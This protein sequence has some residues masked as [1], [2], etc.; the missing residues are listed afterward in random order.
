MNMHINKDTFYNSLFEHGPDIIL[1]LDKE[2][3][4]ANAN[5]N[6]Y[7]VIGY[8]VEEV[9]HTPL[10][11]Y[12]AENEQKN[13]QNI[14]LEVLKGET[15]S[16]DSVII[17]KNGISLSTH[18]I[19]IPATVE[20]K[21][22]GVYGII[23]DK[24]ETIKIENSLRASE[25][26][27]KAIVEEA[28][29]G[30]YILKDKHLIYGNPYYHQ[31]LG[32]KYPDVNFDIFNYIHPEDIN[33]LQSIFDSLPV[34][35]NGKTHYCRVIRKNG[36]ERKIEAHSKLIYLNREPIILGTII[37]VTE[38]EK[39]LEKINF[40]AYFDQLTKLPNRKSFEEVLDKELVIAKTLNQKLAIMYLDLDRFKY[41][42]DTLGYR[43]GEELLIAI[44]KRL[45]IILGD[46]RQLFRISGE[47]YAIIIQDYRTLNMVFD[48]AKQIISSMGEEFVVEH[49][50]LFLNTSIGISL[51]PNDGEDI[52]SLMKNAAAALLNS[53]QEGKNT[54]K[55]YSSTMDIRTFRAFKLG[56]DIR[57]A[58]ENDQLEYYFQPKV[59]T[60]NNQ[61]IG[62][63]ALIRW[64][65]PEWGILSPNEF[66]PVIEENGLIAEIDQKMNLIL[67]K[68]ITTWQ[69][70][71]LP[72][73]TVSMN[74]S[75]K[76]FLDKNLVSNFQ[77]ILAETKLAPEFIEIEIIE[78]SMLE[79][80]KIV[81]STLNDLIKTGIAISLDD[82][83][84]GYSSLSYLTKFKKYIKT[85]KI[86]R[87]FITE[88]SSD[89]ENE[90]NFITQTMIKLAE[91]MKMSVVAEGVETLEQY[92]LLKQMGCKIVQGYLFSKPIPANEFEELL[93]HGII[94]ITNDI[95]LEN[96]TIEDKR[97][98][99][100]VSLHFPLSGTMTLTRINGRTVDVGKTVVIIENIGLGGLRFITDLKLTVNPNILFEF[101]V[102]LFGETIKLLG[103]IVWM[104]ENKPDI[105]Q[106]GLEYAID[107]SRRSEITPIL[108]KLAL[109]LRNAPLVPDCSFV[110]EDRYTFIK[111]LRS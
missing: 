72:Q 31:L 21:V 90:S 59:S 96:P 102:Y 23:I 17:H 108:N 76:R 98:F 38:R 104:N 26:K 29:V 100:R 101:E 1:F 78:T 106:Y 82:F 16:M 42:N 56:S 22:T 55:T 105:Y 92:H 64:N 83:G 52:I 77:E 30:V 40:L 7:K 43:V 32:T 71:G 94:D 89:E 54:F 66:L 8:S 19:L 97:K 103:T 80:E 69:E 33:E 109:K 15:I 49:Y 45:Q 95:N 81:L 44:S 4:I 62:A 41:T 46:E 84:T 99:F 67:A 58:L 86:D 85:L 13:Y 65:H 88:L 110:T 2:S 63:E 18:I 57:F 68:Q 93:K 9:L 111:K 37:D 5:Q 50:R 107:E 10:T 34:G 20:G 60:E 87:S 73:I 51:F 11:K 47:E 53:K 27:F 74:L 91:R 35:G 36:S 6:F 79:N 24:S 61:I 25:A 39:S 3:V 12:L 75:A 28:L 14:F 70:K 48:L